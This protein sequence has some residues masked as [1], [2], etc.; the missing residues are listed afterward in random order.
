MLE[1]VVQKLKDLLDMGF[2]ME[3][4]YSERKADIYKSYGVSPEG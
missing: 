4:E 3:Y 2:I 1:K